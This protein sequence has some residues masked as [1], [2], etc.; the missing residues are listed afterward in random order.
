MG[1]SKGDLAQ[2]SHTQGSVRVPACVGPA[3]FPRFPKS[4]VP[5][6]RHR[7]HSRASF[8]FLK[9]FSFLLTRP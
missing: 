7:P 8:C 2:L 9:L 4:S 3:S 5:C 1:A 6:L